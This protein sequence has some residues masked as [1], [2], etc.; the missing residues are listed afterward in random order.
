VQ[1]GTRRVLVA[2]VAFTVLATIA[3]LTRAEDTDRYFAWHI[4][5]PSTAAFLGAGYAAGLVLSVLALRQQRWSRIRVPVVTVTAFAVLT[6]VAT[7]P[8]CTACT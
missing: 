3:L 6:L 8:T 4:T 1:P 5:A 7:L 2:F